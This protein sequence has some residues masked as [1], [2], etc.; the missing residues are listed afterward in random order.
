MNENK[1]TVEDRI[2][3]IIFNEDGFMINIETKLII[4][5]LL[6]DQRAE[7]FRKVKEAVPETQSIPMNTTNKHTLGINFGWN[8]CTQKMVENLAKL[9][10]EGK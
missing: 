7:I 3:S 6:T 4:K 9:E 8:T 5:K 10:S 1:Q 2:E